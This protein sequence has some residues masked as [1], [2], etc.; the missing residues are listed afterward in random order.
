MMAQGGIG[1]PSCWCPSLHTYH[2]FHRFLNTAEQLKTTCFR[3][4]VLDIPPEAGLVE[5]VLSEGWEG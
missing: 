2:H 4:G 1:M 5:G 3:G